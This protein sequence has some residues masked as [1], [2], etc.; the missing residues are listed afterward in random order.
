MHVLFDFNFNL[1]DKFC[2]CVNLKDS[3]ENMQIPDELVTFLCMLLNSDRNVNLV[4]GLLDRMT[5]AISEG[6]AAF[7]NTMSHLL[8]SV[9]L[10]MFKF[11]P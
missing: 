9:V 5:S 7:R 11:L 2:D 1:Q 10:K 3:L 8:A 4:M 6:L